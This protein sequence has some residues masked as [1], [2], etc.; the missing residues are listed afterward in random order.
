MQESYENTSEKKSHLSPTVI[1]IALVVLILVVASIFWFSKRPA[2][3][4][5]DTPDFEEL[6]HQ[7]DSDEVEDIETD[8]DLSDFDDLDA[9]LREIEEELGF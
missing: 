2:Q 5:A 6:L 9:E 3:E 4:P 7:S 1:I 8:I